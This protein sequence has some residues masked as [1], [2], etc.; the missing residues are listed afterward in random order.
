[1]IEH[2]T[3]VEQPGW[4]ELRMA[5]W[6]EG[7]PEQHREEMA[8]FLE[9]PGRYV[10]VVAYGPDREPLGFV[11]A[12]V[13][14]DY[15]NG[16]ESSPVAF[17]EGMYVVPEARGQGVAREMVGAVEAWGWEM[18]CSELA[19]DAY[20]DNELSHAVHRALGFEETERVVYFRK[21]LKG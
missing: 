17:L 12:S 16:T 20:L 6:P 4:L 7:T 10:Q 8:S 2:C 9:Q 3:S 11:E 14:T 5:L 18:G 1:M 15:V 13:R 19:S 21:E